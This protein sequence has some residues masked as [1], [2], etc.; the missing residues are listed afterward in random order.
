MIDLDK[1]R[2][3]V[4]GLERD[5]DRVQLYH[6]ELESLIAQCMAEVHELAKQGETER[7]MRLVAIEYKAR[8]ILERWKRSSTN[9]TTCPT[10]PPATAPR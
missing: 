6:S 10:R 4:S 3:F 2:E 5:P 7:K 9:S 1:A 8:L